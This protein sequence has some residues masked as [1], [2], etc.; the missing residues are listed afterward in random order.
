M[1]YTKNTSST[2]Y[3]NILSTKYLLYSI[4]KNMGAQIC[5]NASDANAAVYKVYKVFVLLIRTN[6]RT[7]LIII[8]SHSALEQGT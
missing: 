6:G 1:E 2:K 3:S 8:H 5:K 7:Q 4:R